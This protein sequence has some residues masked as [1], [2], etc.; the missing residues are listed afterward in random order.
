[1]DSASHACT[2]PSRSPNQQRVS[3]RARRI[4]IVEAVELPW[5]S[6]GYVRS[7]RIPARRRTRQGSTI[8]AAS[9]SR[10]RWPEARAEAL[11]RKQM[12]KD[13]HHRELPPP[14]ETPAPVAGCLLTHIKPS[15][16]LLHRSPS[17]PSI[18][19]AHHT[20]PN[21]MH[22][23]SV[24]ALVLLPFVSASV[25]TGRDSPPTCVPC[26]PIPCCVPLSCKPVG[27]ST[28]FVDFHTCLR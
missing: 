28:A 6:A 10:I 22:I 24:V 18:N 4:C 26:G 15:G 17:P 14:S 16:E 25:L 19:S 1:M 5:Q 7:P 8:R 20:R 3:V 27:V 21:A 2:S 13:T 12:R 9:T 11:E 23:F